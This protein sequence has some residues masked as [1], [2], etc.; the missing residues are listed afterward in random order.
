MPADALVLSLH[1]VAPHTQHIIND[2]LE[3][4][5]RLGVLHCS[6]LVIPNYHDEDS[7]LNA[8]QFREWIREKQSEGHEIVLHGY[9]H[10]R[11]HCSK[12]PLLKRLINTYYT[13]GEGEFYDLPYQE[14]QEALRR[15]K[16]VFEQI[17]LDLKKIIG[18][19]APA[20]LLGKEA[21]DAL[22]D[23]G[24]AYTTLLR[25]LLSL[26]GEAP[27]FFPA[28]SM[29]YSVRS[30][31]RRCLSLQWN[32]FLLRDASLRKWPL[33]RISFHPIDWSYPSIKAHLLKSVARS[34]KKRTPNTYASWLSQKEILS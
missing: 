15:G 5:R 22:R 14:A 25:G 20:W 27:H 6:L 10:W 34:L 4:L 17:G 19:I 26:G 7:L 16:R 33:L 23:E 18:F 24:F 31:W 1:D 21:Q 8:P 9:S 32:E 30:S 28:Q 3:T 29:V 11:P 2:Q 13:A 12:D